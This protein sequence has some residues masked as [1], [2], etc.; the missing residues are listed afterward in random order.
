[1]SASQPIAHQH[2][3]RHPDAAFRPVGDDGGLVVMPDRGNV[4]VLNPVGIKIFALLDGSHSTEQIVAA[5]IEEFDVSEE[6]AGADLTEF[7][8]ELQREG[9]LPGAGVGR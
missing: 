1:V 3:R 5:L 8:D 9:L 2:L 4:V 6:R 7:L